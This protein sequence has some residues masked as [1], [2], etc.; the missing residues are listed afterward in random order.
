M[1]KYLK[2]KIN[3]G[4]IL[5]LLFYCCFGCKDATY[6]NQPIKVSTTNVKY[7]LG[8]F[9]KDELLV[10]EISNAYLKNDISKI[11]NLLLVNQK[12]TDSLGFNNYLK[13]GSFGVEYLTLFYQ[14]LYEGD[15]I[16]SFTI[17]IYFP[18][19]PM[20]DSLVIELINKSAFK[21]KL[22]EGVLEYNLE[23][24]VDP[25]KMLI[26]LESKPFNSKKFTYL[27]SPFSGVE[28]GWAKNGYVGS[29]LSNR[30]IFEELKS[31]LKVENYLYLLSSRNPATRIYALE[32]LNQ[33]KRISEKQHGS[34][35]KV[36]NILLSEWP[37]VYI[38][39]GSFRT[40]SRIDS[41]LISN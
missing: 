4:V 15:S 36:K 14:F 26:T 19:N 7:D 37:K 29:I 2:I 13:K 39:D 33:N 25:L 21:L 24:A 8:R 11:E 10:K 1:K 12:S 23:N 20:G 28:Y 34:I 32:Y 9:S 31:K 38:T 41:M 17:H 40:N 22:D 16:K 3:I 30:K 18:N 6:S 5:I 27:M 35:L